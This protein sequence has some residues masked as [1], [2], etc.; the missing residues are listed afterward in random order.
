MNFEVRKVRE[1]PKNSMKFTIVI[2]KVVVQVIP[3]MKQ[4]IKNKTNNNN[5]R[6]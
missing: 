4:A 2:D 6:K 1:F 5:K 3:I